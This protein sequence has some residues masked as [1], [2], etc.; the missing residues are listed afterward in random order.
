MDQAKAQMEAAVGNADQLAEQA[1]LAQEAAAQAFTN[2]KKCE[3]V[4][5]ET[6]AALAGKVV[7]KGPTINL[8]STQRISLQSLLDGDDFEM[9]DNGLFGLQGLEGVEV[10]D[11][12]KREVE[13]R[14]KALLQLVQ[15]ATREA[16]GALKARAAEVVQEQH[17]FTKRMQSKRR[18]GPDGEVRVPE[19]APP[20]A[21]AP[22]GAEGTGTGEE[23][24]AP[25]SASAPSQGATPEGPPPSV[26][27]LFQQ[28]KR[29]DTKQQQEP[30]EAKAAKGGQAAASGTKPK[31]DKQQL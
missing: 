11:E 26:G 27:E 8:E 21:G 2:F 20:P 13:E 23:L 3:Q 25:G 6:V 30:M 19:S 4:Y 16:F 22:T 5:Q 17:N 28:A 18:R 10:S 12:E 29:E 24:T 31:A 1:T 9:D 14:K 15:Q 7:P